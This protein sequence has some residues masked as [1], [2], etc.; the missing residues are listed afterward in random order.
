M[1]RTFWPVI[2]HSAAFGATDSFPKLPK[3][4]PANGSKFNS[5]LK[6][7]LIFKLLFQS[8]PFRSFHFLISF[9]WMNFGTRWNANHPIAFLM[10]VHVCICV[11]DA[12][13]TRAMVKHA[14]HRVPKLE[15]RLFQSYALVNSHSVG[16]HPW[17]SSSQFREQCG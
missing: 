16:A 10:R 4:S 14:C 6:T 8:I 3:Q 17:L 1:H 11:C 7:I 2:A 5:R 15:F 12:L 9:V 13:A